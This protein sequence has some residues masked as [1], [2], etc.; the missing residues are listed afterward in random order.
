MGRATILSLLVTA[1]MATAVV[2]ASPAPAGQDKPRVIEVEKLKDNFYVLRGQGGGGNTAVFVMSAGVTVVDTKNPGWGQPIIDAIKKLTDKPITMIINTHTHGDHV[3]GNVEFPATVDVVAHE[4]A[5]ASMKRMKN[6][7][8]TNIFEMN[9]GRGMPKRTY[10]DRLTIGSG[11]D[12]IDLHY[13][14][15][16]HTDGDTWVLFPA[17][18]VVHAGDIFSG[19]N[20]P[21]L[22]TNNGGT[23]IEIGDTLAKAHAGL[24]KSVDII[25]TGHSTQMTPADL[26]EYAQFNRDFLA[27]V[28]S[29]KKAGRTTAELVS[30]WSMPAKYTGYAAPQPAR[31]TANVEAVYNAIK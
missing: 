29:G 5:A 3:S 13:F 10:R 30:G 4:N 23:G 7:A 18:R 1:G 19:K 15:R 17:L 24:A 16:G 14:G 26:N 22:D 11:A 12:R 9:Q 28:Q 6:A 2:A 25:I 27:Y 21:L 8:G 31:L 20:L